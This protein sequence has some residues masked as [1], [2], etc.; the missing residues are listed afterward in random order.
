MGEPRDIV[1]VAE[2]QLLEDVFPYSLPPHIVFDGKVVEE[3][4]GRLVEFDPKSLLERDIC[5]TDT[6]FRDGQQARPPY[7]VAQIR[8]IYEQ[9][10][11]LSG[12]NGVIRQ[13]EYFL[14]SKKDRQAV[15]ACQE[16]GAR[17][18]EITGWVRADQGDISLVEKMGLRESGILTSCS[19]YHIFHKLR[20]DRRTILDHYLACVKTALELGIRPRCHLEDVTRADLDG[21]VIPF[22]QQLMRISEEVPED[23]KVKIRLCDT[24]GFG[25]S[26]PGAALPRSVP[27]LVY[28]MTHD[29]GVPSD[30]LEWHGHNDFHKVHGNAAT[31]WLYGC[32]AV[33]CTLFGIGERTGNPPLE[34]SL[35]EY[36]AIKGDLCG[37]ETQA[38][39]ELAEWYER[40]VGTRLAD[41]Y[42]FVGRHFNTTR[43]GIH[44][45]GLHRD[46]RI[47]NIFDTKALLGRS[48]GV[49]ITDKAGADGVMLWVNKFLG[50]EGKERLSKIKLVKLCRFVA[51]EYTG[52]RITA[53]SEE[54]MIE[55]I[56][57]HLPQLYEERVRPRLQGRG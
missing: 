41:N 3:I 52:G 36:I 28:R 4:D 23:K 17:Y 39:T 26:Y 49:A 40:E 56:R 11:R 20:K 14:Y 55:Q 43:A 42:P 33:N 21:F 8:Y 13:T 29:A 38:L 50:L 25:L 18:P 34:G 7:T 1:E 47:Y 22:V 45:D 32:N 30:R 5:I 9:L 12:P 53:I 6:T 57:E 46:E 16:V 24:M 48:P 35:F 44:A 27:K 51:D 19:D 54:E 37:I 10:V 2:P 15:E 31:A